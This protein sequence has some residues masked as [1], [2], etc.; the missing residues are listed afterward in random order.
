[1]HGTGIFRA[2]VM[3]DSTPDKGTPGDPGNSAVAAT[4]TDW[5]LKRSRGAATVPTPKALGVRDT[6]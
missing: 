3:D 1:M 5:V 4:L 2:F 6:Y